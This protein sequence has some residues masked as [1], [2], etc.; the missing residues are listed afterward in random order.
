MKITVKKD[1]EGYLAEVA[2]HE[3]VFAFA[4]TPAQ[5]KVELVGVAEM[6]MDYHI[7]QLEFQRKLR[8]E[9]LAKA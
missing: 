2:G 8:G 3:N 9:L 5:A 4:D 7:E 6:M 1:G